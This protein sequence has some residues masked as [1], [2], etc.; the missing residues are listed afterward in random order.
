[1]CA[2]SVL[3]QPDISSSKSMF[4]HDAQQP[5]TSISSHTL[6]T[7]HSELVKL[8]ERHTTA[9]HGNAASRALTRLFSDLFGVRAAMFS[10]PIHVPPDQHYF[11]YFLSSRRT[12]WSEVSAMQSM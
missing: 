9:V 8:V 4:N 12:V 3:S 11:T 10:N 6:F 1:M 5:H 2:L 7:F